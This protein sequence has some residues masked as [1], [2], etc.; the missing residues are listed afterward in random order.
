MN[1]IDHEL[2]RHELWQEELSKKKKADILLKWHFTPVL[3][4]WALDGWDSLGVFLP[5]TLFGKIKVLKV[6]MKSETIRMNIVWLFF[7]SLWLVDKIEGAGN[8]GP[9]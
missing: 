6:K 2:K 3:L 9:R 8:S 7:L 5:F 1:I 4:L